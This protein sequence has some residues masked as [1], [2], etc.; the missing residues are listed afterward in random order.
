MDVDKIEEY[1]MDLQ[2]D[3]MVDEVFQYLEDLK[4]SGITNMFG[5]HRYV[6]DEFDISKLMTIKFVSTWMETYKDA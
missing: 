3:E 5:A 1:D 2:F 6:M 4:E